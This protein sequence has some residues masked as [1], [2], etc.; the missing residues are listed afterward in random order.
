VRI[1]ELDLRNFRNYERAAMSL[2]PGVTVIHGPVGAGKTNL[3]E[4][5]Y[6]GALGKS[7]RTA[8]DRELVRFG[9]SATRVCVTS[10]NGVSQRRFEV[11]LEPGRLK[12]M[13]VDGVRRERLAD[14]EGRPLMCVF[15]PD[16]LELV[17][18][19]A[20][21]RRTHLDT[22]IAALRPAQRE[23]RGL[24]GRALAQ[25]N[26]LLARVRA[27][28]ASR[29]SLASWN[30]ELA[31]R[32]IELMNLR[33]QAV[34]LIAP[35]FTRHARELGFDGEQG[36]QGTQG[37]QEA[38][39][40]YR[41]SAAASSEAE[42]EA[43]LEDA[44]EKD[45]ERGFTVVGP[46]RDDVRIEAGGRELRRFGSQGQQRLAL[47]ALLLAERDALAESAGMRPVLLLDDVMS[48]LDHARRRLLLDVL[49]GGGQTLITT[50]D[51]ASV[52][53]DGIAML[54]VVEGAVDG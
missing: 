11:G 14:V 24:Y 9:E 53:A 2:D 19:P 6:F 15:M 23:V 37:T 51:P 54:R 49:L 40:E 25:R 43:E 36:G 3:L 31:I 38:A 26:M 33:A 18:G 13:K 28:V 29:G 45:V 5:I 4:A 8:N 21:S 17:K 48:E 46:H 1:A 41:P 42:L 12:V 44:T 34:D 39:I 30:R 47:L 16:R 52:D 10:A 27:G 50:A 35:Y 22:V 32:G 7:F 20:A